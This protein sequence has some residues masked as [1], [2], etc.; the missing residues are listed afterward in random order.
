MQQ[1]SIGF[2]WCEYIYFPLKKG[3]GNVEAIPLL[4]T[5]RFHQKCFDQRKSARLSR[6]HELA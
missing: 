3:V 6:D 2:F 1:A 4:Y 5:V